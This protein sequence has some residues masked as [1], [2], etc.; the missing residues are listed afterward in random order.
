MAL[1]LVSDAG[2]SIH[3]LGSVVPG[4]LAVIVH[5]LSSAVLEHSYGVLSPALGINTTIAASTL[6][7]SAFALPFYLFRS[8]MLGFPPEPVLP[9]LSLASIPFISY[10][11]LFLSPI[12]LRS[13]KEVSPTSRHVIVSYPLSIFL[14]ASFGPLAFSH[15]PSWADVAIAILLYTGKGAIRTMK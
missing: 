10:S 2:F 6:G 13:L 1:S 11:L 9:L 8:F 4:Y 3:N 5:G 14:A 12:A 15:M 7:A